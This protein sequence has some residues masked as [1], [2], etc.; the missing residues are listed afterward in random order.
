M[1]QGVEAFGGY[2]ID[3]GPCP[4][5]DHLVINVGGSRYDNSDGIFLGFELWVSPAELEHAID[6]LADLRPGEARPSISD[7]CAMVSA[8]GPTGRVVLP[9]FRSP[10]NR[11]SLKD[12]LLPALAEFQASPE[13]QARA[14]YWKKIRQPEPTV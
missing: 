2:Q 4:E 8:R 11:Q 9:L 7:T 14:E 13:T 3:F 5:D 10:E 1:S 6:V 12:L